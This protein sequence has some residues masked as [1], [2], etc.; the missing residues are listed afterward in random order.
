MANATDVIEPHSIRPTSSRPARRCE[1]IN[2]QTREPCTEPASRLV[3]W[4]DGTQARC[5][6]GCAD[7]LAALAQENKCPTY[8]RVH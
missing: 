1:S 4:G 8:I 5:C 7:H 2:P 6:T 3:E